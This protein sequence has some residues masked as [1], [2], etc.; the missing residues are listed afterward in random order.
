MLS[1]FFSFALACNLIVIIPFSA[2]TADPYPKI[3]VYVVNKKNN[4]T[5][6]ETITNTEV[7]LKDYTP[8]ST[9]KTTSVVLQFGTTSRT[10]ILTFPSILYTDYPSSYTF[11]GTLFITTAGVATCLNYPCAQV[12][13]EFD[14]FNSDSPVFAFPSHPPIPDTIQNISA[15]YLALDPRG[16]TWD[17]VWSSDSDYEPLVK[18]LM[19]DMGAWNCSPYGTWPAAASA[20]NT[21]LYLTATSTSTEAGDEAGVTPAP[22]ASPPKEAPDPAAGKEPAKVEPQAAEASQIVANPFGVGKPAAVAEKPT[23]AP[24][25]PSPQEEN[26]DIAALM[27][28]SG[29]NNQAATAVPAAAANAVANVVISSTNA[30]GSILVATSQA[31]GVIVTSTNAQGSQVVTTIPVVSPQALDNTP[32]PAPVVVNG[33]TLTTDSQSHYVIAGQI[34]SADT[35]LV[36]GSGAS[37]TPVILQTS[38]IHPVLVIGSSTTTLN[39]PTSTPTTTTPLAITIGTQTIT[40]NAQGQ[41]LI[42]SQMLTPGGEIVVGGTTA[43]GGTVAV[44]GTT[45]SLAP[46]ATQAVV[47]TSTEGLAPYIVGG[48]GTGPNGTGAVQFLGVAGAKVKCWGSRYLVGMFAGVAGISWLF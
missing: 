47:G 14:P 15:S 45:V 19:P 1:D 38:G 28:V 39:L 43:P 9:T 2:A 30:Q 26:S 4:S 32:E 7:D 5:R 27:P 21:A 8:L 33:H 10:E 46:S 29:L 17:A 20:L 18:P 6:T 40:A 3:L 48:L 25:P 41:Y 13:G 16:S 11:C 12:S 35:P 37:T 24:S 44:G 36:L 23:P 42:G 34:L 22:K 31:P